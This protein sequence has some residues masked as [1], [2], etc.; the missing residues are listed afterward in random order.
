MGDAVDV[1]RRMGLRSRARKS[2]EKTV[3]LPRIE[4][5]RT[6]EKDTVV[7]KRRV[8][9]VIRRDETRRDRDATVDKV[10]TGRPGDKRESWVV[11]VSRL[12]VGGEDADRVSCVVSHV[13][14]TGEYRVCSGVIRGRRRRG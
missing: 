1:D 10:T 3:V 7:T 11:A 13:D 12:M 4:S 8:R 5:G 9:V 6:R 2:R 14:Q